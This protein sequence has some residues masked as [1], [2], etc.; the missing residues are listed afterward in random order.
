MRA[1][2]GRPAAESSNRAARGSGG[3]AAASEYKKYG[4]TANVSAAGAFAARRASRPGLA[5]CPP[6][7]IRS[8][9]ALADQ[10]ERAAGHGAI[11]LRIRYGR[12]P[13]NRVPVLVAEF[14]RDLVESLRGV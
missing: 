13:E 5:Y 1:I 14:E 8:G 9:G 4:A 10:P 2:A 12:R 6:T 3:G 11:G 7:I